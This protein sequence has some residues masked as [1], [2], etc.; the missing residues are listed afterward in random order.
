M[1]VL[2]LNEVIEKG[3][4]LFESITPSSPHCD[5]GSLTTMAGNEG[6]SFKID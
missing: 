6:R 4:G 3:G 5:V 1:V 2:V